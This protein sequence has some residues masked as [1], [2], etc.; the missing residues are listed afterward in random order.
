MTTTTTD[1]ATAQQQRQQDRLILERQVGRLLGYADGDDND[2]GVVRD[3]LGHLL[4][5]ESS[6]VRVYVEGF[7][8]F[9]FDFFLREKP[10]K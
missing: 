7:V 1:A 8:D 3:V 9:F 2:D 4:T 6:E 10:K 5:M